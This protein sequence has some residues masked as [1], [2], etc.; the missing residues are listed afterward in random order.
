MS[1]DT[2]A[3][4]CAPQDT[5]Q[6]CN[7]HVVG[8][9]IRVVLCCVVALLPPLLKA[10]VDYKD[11][12]RED[13]QDAGDSEGSEGDNGILGPQ[14]EYHGICINCKKG[15]EPRARERNRGI[16]GAVD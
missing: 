4:E 11:A 5:Y 2:T 13:D 3:A 6:L 1:V 9:A 15:E 8:K 12:K 7:N 14:A 16:E 10:H